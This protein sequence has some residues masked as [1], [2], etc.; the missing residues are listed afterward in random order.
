MTHKIKSSDFF[1]NILSDEDFSKIEHMVK[2]QNKSSEFEV[3]FRNINYSNYV[4]II[5]YYIDVTDKNNLSSSN[6]LDISVILSDGNTYRTSF[7][8]SD[9]I[10][11]FL[12]KFSKEGIPEIQNYILKLQPSDDIEIMFKDRGSAEKLFIEDLGI[13]F[14]LTKEI[15]VSDKDKPKL[16]GIEKMLY[17][18]KQRSSF[19]IKD[20]FKIDIT[21]VKESN[22]L[23]N[24]AS[25][26]SKYE[27]ELEIT[28]NKINIDKLL[29]EIF[30]I[31]KVVQDTDTPISRKEA[32][33]VIETYKNLLQVKNLTTLYSR[34][35]I[36][37]EAQHIV[38][39]IPNKYAVTDKADGERFFL[40]ILE[41]GTY[42][43]SVNMIVKKIEVVIPDKKFYNTILDGEL[44]KNRKPHLFMAFD[45]VYA[46]NT[47]Y[48]YN[49]KFVLTY[50]LNILK[51]IIDQ[52]FGNL[53]PFY[54]Y[55]DKNTDLELDKIRSYYIIELK[56]Y[57]KLFRKEIEKTNGIFITRKIYFVPYGIDPSEVFM[58]ADLLWKLLVYE[59]LTPYKLDGIIY[60]PIS[61]PY[62]IKTGSD[63]LDN[64]ALE[65]KWKPPSQNTIDFYI[66]FVKDDQGDEAIFYDDTV[67]R[68]KGKMYKICKLYVGTSQGGQEK[69]VQFKVSGKE[70][71]SNIYLID[72]EPRDVEGKV[73][74]DET[75]VEF[76]FDMLKGDID[77][78]YKWIPM[79][80]RYDKTESV[81]KY[82]RKYGN[83]LQ[84]AIRIWKT[85]V[86]PITEDTITSLG[87][88]ITYPK[89]IER[90]SKSSDTY[91]KQNFVYY[92]LKSADAKGMRAF[93][94]WIKSSMI[95]TYC[96]NKNNVLD[97]GCGRGG[98]LNK[99]VQAGIKEYVGIDI[100]NNGLYVINDSA[101]NRYK[102]LRSSHKNVPPMYFI[103]ADVRGL[104][105]LKTQE[106]IIPKM[107]QNNKNL[108]ET[109]LSKN[110]KY[111]V[112]NAQF[113]I[114]YYLS[115]DL[116][117]KNFCK[118][119]NDH[120]ADNGYL[121]I[122]TFDGDMV[123]SRL[124]DKPKMTVSYTDNKGNKNIFFEIVKIYLDNDKSNL[125]M[126]IDLYNSL[127]SG[128][129][130]YIREYLVFP[131][132]LEKSLK[133]NCGLEL[134]ESDLFF[135]LFNLYRNYFTQDMA[136]GDVSTKRYAEVRNF[137]TSL[138]QNSQSPGEQL[139]IALASFKLSML[140]RYYVFK[141]TS[142]ID[143][144]EPSR[145]VGINQR[146]NPGNML[147]SY[148]DNNYMVIDQSKKSKIINRIYHDVKKIHRRTKP[149]VYLIRHTINEDKLDNEI[150]RN[151]KLE[152]SKIKEGAD[153]KTLLI[154]KSPDKYFFPIYYQK[155]LEFK[156]ELKVDHQYD[157]TYLIESEKI[158]S[159]LDILV[160]LSDKLLK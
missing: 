137:Y 36:S 103:N 35:V 96:R 98:D 104:L 135:N 77:D 102:N 95:L 50:R 21:D 65:Y 7:F 15:P 89:E 40:L 84:I 14:K 45:V 64:Q 139:D 51:Q 130:V 117:W 146:I 122:T 75:V 97:I 47:D 26:I 106:K 72:G 142:N 44:I 3:S 156:E 61:Y 123:Y 62:L 29:S 9:Y 121:L 10:E 111:D 149:S 8:G 2:N 63:N 73:I 49:D 158:L 132:F 55:T 70:Q 91:K 23:R 22:N 109:Y 86:N 12:Q 56:K 92:Q 128:P 67:T 11:N 126:A 6:S 69:P 79:R 33:H 20:G 54:D 119:I 144:S 127:I 57:W 87:N 59:N 60:T 48:R 66:K 43:L 13:L 19:I 24:L 114:H 41:S 88:S 157:K 28:D 129:N 152:F 105:D 99:F 125:G 150:Y 16:K 134:V 81:Q 1:N 110:K 42:L 71:T 25:T 76:S 115:D 93:N 37:I 53:V 94:N 145:I 31:L 155:P 151:N 27:F 138:N 17:R 74:S 147:M 46:N 133:K 85:I 108:I 131:E 154:Y 18:Y 68:G 160:A 136:P 83:H 113:T 30:S 4:R 148:F 107:G 101:Y 5:E 140:N 39:Y 80:T 78:A 159:D 153:P 143:M 116:S 124:Q 100:D 90:L 34:N 112:I 38:K 32:S 141:K 58:Y 120:I 118:N 52:C 82:G